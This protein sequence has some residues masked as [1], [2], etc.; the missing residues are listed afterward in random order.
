MIEADPSARRVLGRAHVR[1]SQQGIRSSSS[2]PPIPAPRPSAISPRRFTLKGAAR[3]DLNARA[4]GAGGRGA[5]GEECARPTRESG[6][7]PAGRGSCRCCRPT[8]LGEPLLQAAGMGHGEGPEPRVLFS[9]RATD[10]AIG[11][12]DRIL[13]R[14]QEV[15]GEESPVRRAPDAGASAPTRAASSASFARA[16][17]AGASCRSPRAGRQGMAGCARVTPMARATASWWRPNRPGRRGAWDCARTDHRPVGRPRRAQGRQPDRDPRARDPGRLSGRRHRGGRSL[18]TR[19]ACRAHRPAGPAADHHRSGRRAGPLT[20]PSMPMPTTIRRTPAAMFIWVAIADVAHYVR[21]G[22]ALDREAKRRGNSTYFPDRVVPMLPD[23]LSG[24]LCSLHEE[25]PRACI[26]VRMTVSEDGTL[27]D[28]A[29]FRG[30]MRSRASLEYAEVQAAQD[31]A[32]S[33]RT[34]ERVAD[35]I[36]PLYAALRCAAPRAGKPSAAGP[37]PAGTAHRA[38]RGRARGFGG[39]QGPA[40]CPSD[41]RGIHGAGQCRRRPHA[42]RETHPA[43]VSRARGTGARE[44]RGAARNGGGFG[45][46]A[47][48]GAG[49]ADLA[50]QPPVAAGRRHGA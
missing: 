22:S 2:S 49:A 18:Q 6:Q 39:L 26:A 28:H 44:D 33:E 4:E 16:P 13:A 48:Q 46:H 24:D 21:P 32:P 3:I 25:V 29:F 36:A 31:G 43:A 27:R 7:A 37:R 9:A 41:D 10:P 19:G 15:Q 40:R 47:G 30:L 23:R 35:I 50:A 8:I 14:L 38:D 5:P 1:S 34:A 20:M 42:G 12:G 17:R 45:L 11:G